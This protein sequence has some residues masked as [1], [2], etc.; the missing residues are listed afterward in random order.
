MIEKIFED[1]YNA[2]SLIDKPRAL[3]VI[4]KALEQGIAAEDI[5]FEVVVPG[6][7]KNLEAF[8]QK[9]EANL[10][11]HF[12][13]TTIANEIVDKLLPHF[14]QETGSAGKVVL[15]SAFGDF[16]GLGKK[17]VGGCLRA[18][19]FRTIDLGLN[20][21]PRKFV[22]TAIEE[23]A[24]IIGVSSMMMHTAMGENGPMKVGELLRREG[25]EDRIKLL[26]GGA[27]YLFD[28]GLYQKVNAHGWAPNGLEAVRVIKSLIGEMKNEDRK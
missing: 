26:V 21:A 7:E 9:K 28:E 8:L 18:N 14:K 17:I 3:S 25:L 1:Y 24:Q 11:R 19:M 12:L 15:G 27:P 20:V 4:D 6:I 13:V 22:D 2:I 10:S 23:K 16:H 5:V